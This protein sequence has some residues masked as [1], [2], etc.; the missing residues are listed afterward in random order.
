MVNHVFLVLGSFSV[1]PAS[2]GVGS[3]L[4]WSRARSYGET[5]RVRTC[6]LLH[7][8]A[9]VQYIHHS[10]QLPLARQQQL[11]IDSIGAQGSDDG[12]SLLNSAWAA[13]RPPS[14]F[15]LAY[16]EVQLMPKRKGPRPSL[17]TMAEHTLRVHQLGP[18][19][20]RALS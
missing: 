12:Q 19:G 9:L 13:H 1:W 5:N 4:T 14:L 20:H 6:A 7:L 8:I 18:L 11:T 17:S 2:C 3:R 15:R 16:Y 10:R